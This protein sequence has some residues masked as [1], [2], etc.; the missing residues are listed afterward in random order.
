MGRSSVNTFPWESPRIQLPLRIGC[1]EHCVG[2]YSPSPQPWM[3]HPTIPSIDRHDILGLT[4]GVHVLKCT[5]QFVDATQHN[6]IQH[7]QTSR[8]PTVLKCGSTPRCKSC[9]KKAGRFFCEHTRRCQSCQKRWKGLFASTRWQNRVEKR[10]KGFFASAL[11]GS[12][13]K[14][15]KGFCASTR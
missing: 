7:N 13:L 9:P 4:C 14:R 6:T 15:W 1:M 11:A 5:P 3:R 10:W 12:M 2:W 8:V